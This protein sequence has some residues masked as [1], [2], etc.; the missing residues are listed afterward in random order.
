MHADRSARQ[1]LQ[2][3]LGRDGYSVVI[4]SPVRLEPPKG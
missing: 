1:M 3:L 2:E 4:N